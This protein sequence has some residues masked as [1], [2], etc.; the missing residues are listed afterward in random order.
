MEPSLKYIIFLLPLLVSCYR[1]PTEDDYSVVP[2]T[3][4]RDI[5]QEKVNPLPQLGGGR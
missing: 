3:N 5:T 4:N 1:M 2:L